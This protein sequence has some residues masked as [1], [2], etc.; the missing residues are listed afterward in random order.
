MT[1]MSISSSSKVL[2][3]IKRA[4]K[5]PMFWLTVIG[6][7]LVPALYNL[8]FLTSMWDPYGRVDRLPVAVV[9][10]DRPA[11][12]NGKTIDLGNDITT[13]LKEKKSL[14]FNFVS[15]EKAKQGLDDGKYYMTITL[16][17]SLSQKATTLLTDHP[18]QTVIEYE[19]RK[20]KS[21]VASKMSESAI[22]KLRDQV[23]EEVIKTYNRALFAS[24]GDMQTGM[25]QA[26]DG[27]GQL[28]EGSNQ[29][30]AGSGTLRNGLGTL[31]TGVGAYSDGVSQLYQGTKTL[32]SNSSALVGGAEQLQGSLPQVGQLASG[33]NQLSSALNQLSQAT[34]LSAEQR[35]SIQELVNGL[36]QLQA[37]INQ[38][39]TAV[40]GLPS[41][42]INMEAIT[43]NLQAIVQSTQTILTQVAADKEAIVTNLK[44]TTSYQ[45]LSAD[46][47]QELESA[48]RDTP[49]A[50][51]DNANKILSS[52]QQL[53]A[54]LAQLQQVSAGV[55]NQMTA[56]QGAV[57]NINA[58]ANI[59]LPGANAAIQSL[60]SGTNQVHAA[61]FS[62]ILPGSQQVAGGT[63]VLYHQLDAGADKLVSGVTAYT[64]GVN[65]LYTGAGTLNS[66]NSELTSGVDQLLVGSGAL[67]GGMGTLNSGLQV[68]DGSLSEADKQ[69]SQVTVREKNA[70]TLA[71]PITTKKSDPDKVATN[72][73]GMAPYMMSVALMVV[74]LSANVVFAK[75]LDGDDYENRWDWLKGKFI[76]NGVIAILSG[77]FL[78]FV[79]LLVGVA[80]AHPVATYFFTILSSGVFMALV[81]ALIGWNQR[82]GSFAA[83]ILL[84]LQLGSSA[85]TYPIELSPKFFAFVQPFLP[86]T[87]T[88]SGLRQTIS[89]GDDAGTQTIILLGFLALFMAFGVVAFTKATQKEEKTFKELFTRA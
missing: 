67:S 75:N 54:V 41:V 49:S 20:G 34:E 59:A 40:S 56:L 3:R 30:L 73:V 62:Q 46:Q 58:A 10:D 82:F 66:K 69:L 72:G 4:V 70:D 85:G 43:T 27:T 18:E 13:S 24:V 77:T 78:Y 64:V 52:V 79:V 86:M 33:A 7:S 60:Y 88:V 32:N 45:S 71:S 65:S 12:L 8:S 53:S 36:P 14:D 26:T 74:A 9:N 1:Q 51:E 25:R 31:Q 5:R 2:D 48:I 11:T 57:G 21:F 55:S 35:Q 80:Y 68:L 17:S 84:V 81:T 83:L 28:L 19:T 16:P 22:T 6:V 44:A 89:M 87:Y 39:N 61:V 29:L 37:G 42:S 15:R 63:N 47:Q 38:L 76:L 23:S 50:V